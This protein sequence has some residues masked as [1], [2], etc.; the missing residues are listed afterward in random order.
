MPND[1][2]RLYAGVPLIP[3]LFSHSDLRTE[4]RYVRN[5]SIRTLRQECPDLDF[6]HTEPISVRWS[7]VNIYHFEQPTSL[8]RRKKFVECIF[9]VD[10]KVIEHYPDLIRIRVVIIDKL[11]HLLDEIDFSSFFFNHI[12]MGPANERFT[13]QENVRRSSTSISIVRSH[14]CSQ[15][16]RERIADMCGTVCWFYRSRRLYGFLGTVRGR[17]REY[18][19]CGRRTLRFIWG[20]TQTGGPARL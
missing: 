2:G 20:I 1:H 16:R 17:E 8:I 4:C 9:G 13:D 6:C 18:L 5:S 11:A 12:D 19:P 10:A 15:F 14:D 3:A 7:E